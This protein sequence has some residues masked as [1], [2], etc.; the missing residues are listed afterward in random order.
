MVSDG[1]ASTTICPEGGS[2][3]SAADVR[4]LHAMTRLLAGLDA[5]SAVEMVSAG[6]VGPALRR[7]LLTSCRMAHGALLVSAGQLGGVGQLLQ[8]LGYRVR[9]PVPST[10]VRH[11]LAQRYRLDEQRLDVRILHGAQSAAEAGTPEIEVFVVATGAFTPAMMEAERH[12]A[13]E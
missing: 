8:A 9:P 1:A 3:M 2:V 4:R 12:T 6:S 7:R 10:V 11:R 5:A 13:A